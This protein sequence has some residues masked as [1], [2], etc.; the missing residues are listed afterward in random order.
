M[1]AVFTRIAAPL[2]LVIS[3]IT[4]TTARPAD[5]LGPLLGSWQVTGVTVAPSPVQ[6]V[7][8]DDPSLMG[9]LLDVTRDRL[10]WRAPHRSTSLETSCD[11]PRL[12]RRAILCR[13]G[14]FGPPG[15]RVTRRGDTLTLPWYD[16][17]TLRLTRAPLRGNALASPRTAA[18][19][20]GAAAWRG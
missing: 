5:G 1:N 13:S 3:S 16:G 19:R 2:A 6:A 12:V 7:T 17:A 14:S 20:S 10:S 8:P 9:A 15:S 11:M 18:A 4:P